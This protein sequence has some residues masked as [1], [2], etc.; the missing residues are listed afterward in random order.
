MLLEDFSFISL[1]FSGFS[2]IF[3][4][5]FLLILPLILLFLF[6]AFAKEGVDEVKEGAERLVVLTVAVFSSFFAVGLM[7]KAV[8]SSHALSVRFAQ[9]GEPESFL[10]LTASP[11]GVFH[12]LCGAMLV[13]WAVF[14]FKGHVKEGSLKEV[15][16][17]E[18]WPI[19]TI[20]AL[21]VGLGLAGAVGVKTDVLS[22]LLLSIQTMEQLN[23]G[24]ALL[25]FYALGLALGC[26]VLT[27]AAS[28]A[29]GRFLSALE[30]LVDISS[31]ALAL[32]GVL[33]FYAF[34]DALGLALQDLLP[35][36]GA[37]G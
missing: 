1:I 34:F 10:G 5:G 2:Y 27:F 23:Q 16:E 15:M 6:S 14:L 17:K 20:G 25:F 35:F 32:T 19:A 18:E 37:L 4:G 9:M 8:L 28:F 11:M 33:V 12:M 30:R 7:M 21:L 24:A 26:F 13:A 29:A 31:I 36:L 22:K 3:T